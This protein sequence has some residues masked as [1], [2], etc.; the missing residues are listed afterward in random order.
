MNL[1]W[2][3]AKLRQLTMC[4]SLQVMSDFAHSMQVIASISRIILAS[5][6]AWLKLGWLVGYAPLSTDM[7]EL[8]PAKSSRYGEVLR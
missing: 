3:A 5:N 8:I 2:C 7:S 6:Q 1:L 4:V